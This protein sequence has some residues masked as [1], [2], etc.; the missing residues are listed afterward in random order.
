MTCERQFLLSTKTTNLSRKALAQEAVLATP[1]Y[2]GVG[3][4][5]F[6]CPLVGEV[7]A[8]VV[9]RSFFFCT[10]SLGRSCRPGVPAATRSTSAALKFTARS[11]GGRV[12]DL[13]KKGV[14]MAR[15]SM[16]ALFVGAIRNVILPTQNRLNGRFLL[17]LCGLF[18]LP[19][20][21]SFGQT[22]NEAAVIRAQ[23]AFL[24]GAGSY[25][26]NTAKAESIS[27]DTLI[28]WKQDLRKIDVERRALR[29][30]QQA[31]K[32]QKIED[33]KK[34]MAMREHELR[35]D[36]T[37]ADVQ[38][39]QALNALLY[40]LTDPDISS[41]DWYTK[42]VQ[43]PKGMSV[44]DLIFRFVAANG[45]SNA[46][47]V[48]SRGAIALSRLD[49]KGE[50]WPTFMKNT[51][52]EKECLAYESA[53]AKLREELLANKF[54]VK[55]LLALDRS[56]DALKV[57]VQTAVPKDRG[58]RD[59]AAKFVEELKD[60]TRMFDAVTVDYARE[61][62]VD[63]K[64]QEAT[65]VAELVSFMLKYRL[66]FGSAERSATGRVL[67]GQIYEAMRQQTQQFGIKPPEPPAVAVAAP[68][69]TEEDASPFKEKSVWRQ[70]DNAGFVLTI[71][72][73]KGETFRATMN[74]TNGKWERLIAGTV[75]GNQVIWLAKDS[76]DLKGGPIGR[77]HFG[78]I[79]SDKDGD[80]LDVVWRDAVGTGSGTWTTMYR[81]K[82]K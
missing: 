17:L 44:K 25:N 1:P 64:D 71:I 51:G 63:T 67:Y 8:V 12:G 74:S 42:V 11:T 82:D 28:R 75:K 27:V 46:S 39:G 24:Q 26:L 29:E 22:Q 59:E 13:L 49:V 14:M 7:G 45:S 19:Q 66:Q 21:H 79:T 23:G 52:L 18:F 65:T 33:V 48:L 38:N 61:I 16:R 5:L 30:Q 57:K 50:S 72:E 68:A 43:L 41:N 31:G 47:K 80:K 56:L 58:F 40:D 2:G 76:R 36:P 20:P 35:V 78:T 10:D 4:V 69:A 60:A 70:L 32:K 81:K 37:A 6:L 54:E 15:E 77:D 9:R 3:H 55:T 73:R 53:Y 34:R 62:L